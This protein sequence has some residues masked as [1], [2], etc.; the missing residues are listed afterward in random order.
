MHVD[1]LGSRDHA[2]AAAAQAVRQ[3]QPAAAGEHREPPAGRLD[4]LRRL[5]RRALGLEQPEV[6]V[7][8]RERHQP[9]VGE[10]DADVLRRVLDRHRDRRGIGHGAEEPHQVGLGQARRARRLEDGPGRAQ[11]RRGAHERDLAQGGGLRDRDRERQP[12]GQILRRPRQHRA[13]LLR[14]QLADLGAEPEHREPVRAGGDARL[15]LAPHRG[16]VEPAVPAEEGVEDRIDAREPGPLR[17]AR[18]PPTPPTRSARC[19]SPASGAHPPRHDARRGRSGKGP[20]PRPEAERGGVAPGGD[21]I[22][23]GVLDTTIFHLSFEEQPPRPPP[24]GG[25][26]RTAGRSSTGGRNP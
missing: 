23:V 25:R 16:P 1:A 26:A 12:A 9:R 24:A 22:A 19:R 6:R 14:R 11:V 4:Q 20:P 18:P 15:D 5:Q 7:R 8:A 17:H 21:L 10:P 3:L 13:P 2:G